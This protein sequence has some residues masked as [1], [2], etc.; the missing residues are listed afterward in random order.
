MSRRFNLPKSVSHYR[1]DPTAG[2]EGDVYYNSLQE[3]FRRFDGTQWV[4]IGSGPQGIQGT[5]GANGAQGT[6][7]AQGIQGTQGNPSFVTPRSG[8]YIGSRN[9]YV[10]D[11]LGTGALA[12]EDVIAV[13][14][15]IGES[16]TLDR[17]AV[18]VTTS[19]TS[20]TRLGIYNHSSTAFAPGTLL[21][22]GG[23][24]STTSLGTKETTISQAVTPGVYW[25]AII[26]NYT[27][28]PEFRVLSANGSVGLGASLL[29]VDSS[30]NYWVSTDPWGMY[31]RLNQGSTFPATFGGAWENISLTFPVPLIAVRRA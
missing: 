23:L 28:A 3:T 9:F 6:T 17:I 24:I 27:T 20:T 4:D 16:M 2:I 14:I 10:H 31:V 18:R 12:D 26:S 21:V 19:N 7:G 8:E 1:Q 29:Y 11:N 5:G 13:P 22:D 25:L 30:T 15:I